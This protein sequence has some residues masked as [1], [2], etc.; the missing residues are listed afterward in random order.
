M[1]RRPIWLTVVV[2]IALL[3]NVL[4][5]LAV[6]ADLRLSAADIA[7]LPAQQQALYAARPLWSVGAS[8]VAVVGGTLGCLALLLRKR[9]SL[10]LLYASLLGVVLQDIGLFIV[11][12]AAKVANPVPFI[13]Q[14]LVLV[15][16]VGLVFLARHADSKGWLTSPA[17]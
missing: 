10:Y 1:N 15:V 7:A 17:A 5:L 12:G 2:S 13:M 14:G 16:S 6:L 11:A 8:I 3:W 4:G 9:A